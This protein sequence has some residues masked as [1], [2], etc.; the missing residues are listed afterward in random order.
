M[1]NPPK[2]YVERTPEES[3]AMTSTNILLLMKVGFE[4]FLSGEREYSPWPNP[5]R[6]PAEWLSIISLEFKK[7]SD[8]GRLEKDILRIKK[9]EER[10][11]KRKISL[12]NPIVM[13]APLDLGLCLPCGF[14]DEFM[15]KTKNV[16]SDIIFCSSV[17]VKTGIS[18][19]GCVTRS[20]ELVWYIRER[21]SGDV[22][23][24]VLCF[25]GEDASLVCF[26]DLK[27]FV[28][29][30]HQEQYEWL[31]KNKYYLFSKNIAPES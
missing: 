26:E 18:H 4:E 11:A 10:M 20:A 2:H 27:D 29:L 31:V 17:F 9:A 15:K 3:I 13:I 22:T 16:H 19:T 6:T 25:L 30:N 24:E 8:S 28:Y 14:N 1:K 12:T 5:E 21:M 23:G 7:R